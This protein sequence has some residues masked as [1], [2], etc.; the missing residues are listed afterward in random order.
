MSQVEADSISYYDAD[1]SNVQ[2]R[3]YHYTKPH[4][5]NRYF[6][7]AGGCC[8]LEFREPEFHGLREVMKLYEKEEHSMFGGGG[9]NWLMIFI[10]TVVLLGVL[11]VLGSVVI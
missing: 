4:L 5:H 1:E 6:L 11:L 9:P 3:I 8:G 2:L 7:R 10:A